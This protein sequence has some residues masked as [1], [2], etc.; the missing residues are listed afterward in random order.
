MPIVLTIQ[1]PDDVVAEVD[2]LCAQARAAQSPPPA[3]RRAMTAAERHEALRI[4][5]AQGEKA[6]NEYADRV[7]GWAERQAPRMPPGRPK[8]PGSRTQVLV[9]LVREAV[10]A[11]KRQAVTDTAADEVVKQVSERLALAR[12][13][14]KK[15]A[16]K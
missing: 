4:A 11:R 13:S 3:E 15:E 6:A 10:A 14:A 1:L 2:L 9:A 16:R 12:A 8:D 7:T 5:K